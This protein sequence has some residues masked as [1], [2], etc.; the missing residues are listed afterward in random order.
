[1]YGLED[2]RPSKYKIEGD[3]CPDCQDFCRS[4][5][6]G[7]DY[8][9]IQT[10]HGNTFFVAIGSDNYRLVENINLLIGGSDLLCVEPLAP[11][12]EYESELLASV[13]PYNSALGLGYEDISM[14]GPLVESLVEAYDFSGPPVDGSYNFA[15]M[16]DPP[17]SQEEHAAIWP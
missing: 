11:Q 5:E 6:A 4:F 13:D 9:D 2:R 17:Q 14:S 12:I 15:P 7:S 10:L 1:M 16:V 3:Y 8:C